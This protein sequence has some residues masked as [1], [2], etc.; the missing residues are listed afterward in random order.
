M[1]SVGPR[2]TIV[3]CVNSAWN[4][5]NFRRGLVRDLVS[6]GFRV[7][8]LAPLDQSRAAFEQLGCEVTHIDL[9][10]ESLSPLHDL[11]VLFRIRRELKRLRPIVMLGFTI[12]PNIYG[13]LAAQSLGIPVVNNIAGLGTMFLRGRLAAALARLF[14]RLALRKSYVVFFQNPDDRNLFV[15]SRIVLPEQA[16]LLPGSGIDLSQFTPGVLP[17]T[18]DTRPV[19]F[20]LI[21][22]LLR[23]KGVVEYITAART[24]NR[25]NA[26]ARFVLVGGHDLLNSASIS[27]ALLNNAIEE[28]AIE[29]VGQI[30]DV[31]TEIAKA[32][33]IVL[34]SYR[35]GLPRTLLE[36]AAMGRP[37]IATDVPGCREVVHEG[38]TGLLCL[39]RDSGSLATALRRMV[40]A[41]ASERQR[42][43]AN[44]RR[45]VE[46]HF[47]ERFVAAAYHEAIEFL[48]DR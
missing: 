8:V 40:E 47:D 27:T 48:P 6:N 36:G 13:S 46:N 2:R 7:V 12:K 35:E 43:G 32:D 38:A 5:V 29:Y 24:L 39:P 28:A 4:V 23:D 37:L 21:A 26:N 3:I 44:A 19:M 22:R 30:E 10:R 20:L 15:Q 34:P 33:C 11:K 18:E 41:G 9:D 14:Y 1:S 16:R 25:S 45:M 31:R 17:G 42:M